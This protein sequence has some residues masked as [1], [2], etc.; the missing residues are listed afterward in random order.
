MKKKGLAALLCALLA[1]MLA[2]C[3]NSSGNTQNTDAGSAGTT[4]EQSQDTGSAP[5]T[6]GSAEQ[7]EGQTTGDTSTL[8]AYFTRPDNSDYGNDLDAITSAS[9]VQGEEAVGNAELLSQMIQNK[10]GGTLFAIETV[11]KYPE[12][13]KR[14]TEIAAEEQDEDTRPE[15]SSHVDNMEQYDEVYL[16]YPMWWGDVPQAVK[17]FLE[18]YDFSGKTIHPLSTHLGS[19]MGVSET[20]I[21]ELAS[22]AKVTEGLAVSGSGVESAQSDVDAWIDGMK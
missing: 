21:A 20:T 12:D 11:D 9:V 18:E 17:T 5:R 14:T 22:G 1:C 3:G 4:A 13:Y 10:T 2:A 6:T 8:I 16:V 19:G 15:L 7:A